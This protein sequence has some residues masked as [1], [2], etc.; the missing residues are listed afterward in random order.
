[1]N[2][3]NDNQYHSKMKSIQYYWSGILSKYFLKRAKMQKKKIWKIKVDKCCQTDLCFDYLSTDK[4]DYGQIL[5]H[6]SRAT[7]HHSQKGT[8]N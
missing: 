6:N 2:L 8:V 3:S 1:M 4:Q 5:T 7:K